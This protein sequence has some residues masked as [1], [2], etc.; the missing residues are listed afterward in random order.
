MYGT[1]DVG[2][3]DRIAPLYDLAMPPAD[4]DALAAGFD[5]ATRPI[6]RLLDIGGGSGRAAAA[7]TGPDRLVID[8]SRP[9]LRRARSVRGLSAVAG[10]AGRLPVADDAVD[11]VLVVDAFHHFPAQTAAI[12]EA[13]RVLAPG[14]VFVIR[15][16]DPTHPLG[17][18]LVTAEHTIGMTSHFCSPD[19]LAAAL[20][21]SRFDAVV[22]DRGFGYTVAGVRAGVSDVLGSPT[23]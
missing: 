3:F 14:G 11:A 5:Q 19:E 22:I 21:A 4:K 15:E 23:R 20:S 9:M 1:G 16:F 8:V 12:D 13:A 18:L 6:D 10:D 17:R 7:V 2:F